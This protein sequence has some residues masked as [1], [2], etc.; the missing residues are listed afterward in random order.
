MSVAK[1]FALV[2]VVLIGALLGVIVRAAENGELSVRV[3]R[4]GVKISPMLN[5]LMTEEINHAYDGG[6]Y[7]ELIQ[8]RAFKD[9]TRG[10]RT[11]DPTHPPHWVLVKKDGAD[12][13]M[14]LDTSHPVNG[15]ALTTSLRL[16]SKG[17]AGQIGVANDGF[18]GIPVKA[19]TVYRARFYARATADLQGPLTVAIES[20]DGAKVHASATVNGI[21]S[22][23][24]KFNA[25]LKMGDVPTSAANRF[26]I[27]MPGNGAGSLWLSLVSLF[28]PTYNDRP[29]GLRVDLM[30]MLAGL[31]PAFLRFPGGNY[32]EGPDYD[33]RFNWKTTIGPLE[34]RPGHQCPW[35]YRSSDG[36][37]LLEFLEWC[38]D[39]KMEPVLAVYAGLHID[40]GRNIITGDALRPHV[41]DALDE[42]EYVTGDKTT[43]WG[44]RRAKDGH[45]EPFKLTYVEIGNEDN[46]NRG[47]GSY[48]G[49][50]TMFY[51]AIKAKYPALQ[52]ISTIPSN[53]SL[54]NLT[55]LTRRPD[56]IDDHLYNPAANLMRLSTHYDNDRY[57]G[58]A[59][60]IFMGEWASQ[61]GRP[62]PN[63]NSALGDAAYLSGLQRNSDVVVMECYAPLLVNVNPGASQWGTNLIGYNAVK[64]F[65]SPSYYAQ[66]MFAVNRGDRVLPVELKLPP[67]AVAESPMPKGRVG[68]G[69]WA[70]QSEYKDM[71]VTVGDQ[72]AYSLD[73]ARAAEDW[74]KGTGNW[75][76]DGGTLRQSANATDCR[77]TAGSAD[78]T[79][80]TYTLKARKISGSEGFLILFHV[81]SRDD[82]LWWNIGG[83]GNSRTVIEKHEHGAK[84]ELGSAENVRV[85]ENQWYDVKIEL[86]G[87]QIRCYLDGKL[88]A[89]V[90]DRPSRPPAAVYATASQDDAS[91]DVILKVVNVSG[92]ARPLA[93]NLEGMKNV[94]KQAQLEVLS[95]Q[96]TDVNTLDNPT[97]VATQK[98]TIDNAGTQFVHEFPAYS[99]NVIRFHAH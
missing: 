72:V 78:W 62:T 19:N 22:E 79:D 20:N 89:D 58:N 59:P 63:M 90:V 47:G 75:S 48:D 28:P 5:G 1:R 2:P 67:E 24:K 84:V 77:A 25:T 15:T 53:A 73:P 36:L 23:W 8:N 69:T 27:S 92:T 56:V 81:R 35:G 85:T 14:T 6:L 34:E 97:K 12:G 18:W 60:K 98:T 40:G 39:L 31:K 29:N 41:Q 96:P 52:I 16:D 49:R 99:V 13:T 76:W 11:P 33:N 4:P 71:K 82:L 32:L 61:E 51:D 86:K 43:E 65:G 91:G 83:W 42:I 50:F 38:E 64:G 66:Q 44:A 9:G 45:P 21:G 26:V 94:T 17:S 68:V 37:G 93:M 80:Y 88:V 46:L 54:P 57:R 30:E 74:R 55:N 10:N 7:A 95:G 87:R 70:T 3:D